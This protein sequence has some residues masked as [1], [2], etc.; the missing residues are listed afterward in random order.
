MSFKKIFANSKICRKD[1]YC[2]HLQLATCLVGDDYETA[3]DAPVLEVTSKH[4]CC[5]TG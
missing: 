3:E 1:A 2:Q 5:M 4:K